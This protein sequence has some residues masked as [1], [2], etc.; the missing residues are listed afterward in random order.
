MLQLSLFQ[1]L[2]YYDFYTYEYVGIC[3]KFRQVET[4]LN[5]AYRSGLLRCKCCGVGARYAS[6]DCVKACKVLK[7]TKNPCFF[8][9]V[10]LHVY[11]VVVFVSAVAWETT[12]GCIKSLML[13]E[14]L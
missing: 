3:A 6:S 1:Q 4:Q 2:Y 12:S 5:F 11:V 13:P 8:V 9:R 10:C 14:V 7:H